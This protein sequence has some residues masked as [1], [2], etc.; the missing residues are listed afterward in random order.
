MSIVIRNALLVSIDPLDARPGE[1]RIEGGDITAV[2]PTV[3]H[4]RSDEVVDAGGA[5]VC[6]GMVNGH[7]HLYSALAVGMPPPRATPTTFH[8]ILAHVWW[9]LDRTLDLPL[10]EMSALIGGIEALRCGTTALIDHHASPSAI[11]GS[12]DAIESGLDRVGVRGVLCYETTDRNGTEG[13]D[14]GLAENEHYL[15]RCAGT[16]SGRFAGMAGG[17]AAFTMSDESLAESAALAK[18]YNVGVHLHSDGRRPGARE[19]FPALVGA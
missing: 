14:A 18:R 4:E 17:H 16:R 8:E 2:G 6:P 10:C 3:P 13:R 9:R 12:L 15:N 11:A 5:V 1:L 19:R 7:M